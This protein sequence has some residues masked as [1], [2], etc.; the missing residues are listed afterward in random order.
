MNSASQAMSCDDRECPGHRSRPAPARGPEPATA[1]QPHQRSRNTPEHL[2]VTEGHQDK[3]AADPLMQQLM[4]RLDAEATAQARHFDIAAGKRKFMTWLAGSSDMPGDHSAAPGPVRPAD[5]L[6]AVQLGYSP[7]ITRKLLGSRLRRL[8]EAS[9]I[10]AADA[11]YQ[12]RASLAKISR[13]ELGRISFKERDVT[14]LL[15]LYGVTDPHERDALIYL[16]RHANEDPWWSEY[17]DVL[18]GWFETYLALEEAAAAIRTYDAGHIPALL[19]TE[20]YARALA[21]QASPGGTADWEIGRRLQVLK[22]RQTL[23]T[24][25][26]APL[27][28]I[29]IDE[30]AL[31]RHVGGPDVMPAQLRYLAQAGSLPGVAIQVV[32]LSSEAASVPGVSFAL[33]RFDDS[34]LPDVVYI[35]TLAGAVYLDGQHDVEQHAEVLD[36]LAGSSPPPSESTQIIEDCLRKWS[37]A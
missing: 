25:H 14:D 5:R 11:A 24:R 1:A 35:E 34:D 4:A 23:L 12:I 27:L 16:T 31:R 22:E 36:H 3:R 19:Q 20:D 15:H 28:W 17:S 6:D 30:A 26:R 13:M 32:P 33:L 7:V 29:L 18:P 10:P 21:G 2:A 9:G 37:R 8:R